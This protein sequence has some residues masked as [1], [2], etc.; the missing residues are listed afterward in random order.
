MP[1]TYTITA[2]D[3]A[4][5]DASSALVEGVMF[6]WGTQ[7]IKPPTTV[8]QVDPQ[9]LVDHCRFAEDTL[10]GST[11]EHIIE[12]SGKVQI[13][14]NAITGDPELTGITP[15]LQNDWV[16]ETQKTSGLFVITDVYNPTYTQSSGTPPYI[17]IPGVD[18]RYVTTRNSTIQQ[19]S[20]GNG[21]GSGG[22]GGG[23]GP[24]A[25]AAISKILAHVSYVSQLASAGGFSA[26]DKALLQQIATD[27]GAIARGDVAI[28]EAENTITLYRVDGTPLT[29][30]R[31][32]D[33]NG[34]PTVAGFLQRTR[35]QE[36]S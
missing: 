10:I 23:L 14:R 3:V 16:I 6:D 31:P 29:T 24:G 27:A 12:A 1:P 20:S 35:V 18:I 15:V 5:V 21:G 30:F 13:G 22:E 19:I 25:L 11:R 34:Q 4:S 32:S 33:S 9:W 8:S 36:T 26:E 17:D 28:N 7:R 2:A